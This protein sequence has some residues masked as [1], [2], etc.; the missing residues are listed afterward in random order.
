M[1]KRKKFAFIGAGG[2]AAAVRPYIDVEQ[3]SLIGYFDDIQK[4]TFNGLPILG[5]IDEVNKYI[6]NGEVEAVFIAIGDNQKRA[7]VFNKIK[8]RYYTKIINIISD[9]ATI[10]NPEM[11]RGQGIFIGHN[12]FV[13]ADVEI[14]DNVIINTNTIVEHG[15]VVNSHCNISPAAVVLGDIVLNEGVYIGASSTVKQQLHIEAWTIVGA[16]AV[17]VRDIEA[18][19]TY[20]GIPARKIETKSIRN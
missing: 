18:A 15:T 2:H 4:D 12:A 8:G 17:I 1:E 10:L 5:E 13:G 16:G 3:Y 7:E 11:I 19:G 9:N 14:R 6:E 20:V